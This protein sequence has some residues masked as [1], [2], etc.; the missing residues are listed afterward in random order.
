MCGGALE[1][2]EAA[3]EGGLPS[4]ADSQST[5]GARRAYGVRQPLIDEA[6]DVAAGLATTVPR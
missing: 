1:H 3:N 2:D 5:G 6:D 4:I